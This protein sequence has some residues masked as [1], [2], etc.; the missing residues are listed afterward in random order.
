MNHHFTGQ[1]NIDDM[2]N[3]IIHQQFSSNPIEKFFSS[4]LM[5]KEE[6]KFI[7]MFESKDLHTRIKGYFLN[8]AKTFNYNGQIINLTNEKKIDIARQIKTNDQLEK[9]AKQCNFWE[10]VK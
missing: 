8:L 5:V 6:D 1:K 4:I 10:I 9:L 3:N 7:P 2:I